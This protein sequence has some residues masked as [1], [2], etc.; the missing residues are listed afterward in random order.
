MWKGALTGGP[1]LLAVRIDLQNPGK[2][3]KGKKMPGRMGGE[4]RTVQNAYVFKASEGE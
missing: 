2:V 4:Q 3:F 1:A